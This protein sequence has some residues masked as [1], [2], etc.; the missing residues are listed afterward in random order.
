MKLLAS[1]ALAATVSAQLAEWED[2]WYNW[3]KNGLFNAV[4]HNGGRD[5]ESEEMRSFMDR[6]VPDVPKKNE[7]IRNAMTIADYLISINK[8]STS[9]NINTALVSGCHS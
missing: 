6:A 2:L 1:M 9:S 7:F 8:F 4:N 5:I 3:N